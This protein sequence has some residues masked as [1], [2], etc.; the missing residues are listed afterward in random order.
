MTAAEQVSSPVPDFTVALQA[1]LEFLGVSPFLIAVVLLVFALES[2]YSNG[3]RAARAATTV[4]RAVVLGS[5][6]LAGQRPARIALAITT[7]IAVLIAQALMVRVSYVGGSIVGT[8]FDPVRWEAL[9]DAYGAPPLQFADPEFLDQFLATDAFS[10]SYVLVTIVLL[11]VAYS[12]IVPTGVLWLVATTPFWLLLFGSVAL[13]VISVPFDL[14]FA[15]LYLLGDLDYDWRFTMDYV[16]HPAH[17]AV[18][19]VA[20][21]Y[22]AVAL[23]AFGGAK[24]VRELWSAAADQAG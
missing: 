4:G 18:D 7:T 3:K 1:M 14:L 10:I 20:G 15:G 12:K 22:C 2:W 16:L 8:P 13:A 17:L 6:W 9:D 21:V 5:T 23:A 19:L 11:L 24:V